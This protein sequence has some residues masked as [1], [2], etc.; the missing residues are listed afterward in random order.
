MALTSLV[1]KSKD[2]PPAKEYTWESIQNINNFTR[3][4]QTQSVGN[5]EDQDLSKLGSV[6]SGMPTVFARCNMFKLSLQNVQDKNQANHG[7]IAFY[8]SLISEWRGLIT[9]IALNPDKI[10]VK[11]IELAYSD[12]QT[13]FSVQGNQLYE[14]KGSFGNML[15]ERKARWSNPTVDNPK[16]FLDVIIYKKNDGTNMVVGGTNPDSLFFTS[17]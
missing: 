5:D 4:I 13:S 9:C 17:A 15:F 14:P 7:L 8:E 6:I 12:D 10:K 1:I 2:T 16:P 11:R 3:N